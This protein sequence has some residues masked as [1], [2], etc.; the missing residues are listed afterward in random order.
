MSARRKRGLNKILGSEAEKRVL[1]IIRGM[2]YDADFDH[3][4]ADIIVNDGS[5]VIYVEVKSVQAHIKGREG[6]IHFFKTRV[7]PMLWKS[8]ESDFRGVVVV[9]VRL[10]NGDLLYFSV[11]F[12]RIR[13]KVASRWCWSVK[14][15]K[16]M[17]LGV[18]GVVLNAAHIQA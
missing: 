12:E 14:W 16:L 11:P 13:L 4:I 10:D 5:G 7:A 18:E 2:G 8:H 9:E 3:H 15:T 1:D 6:R 17:A